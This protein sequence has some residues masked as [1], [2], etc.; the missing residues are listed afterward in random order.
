[1]Y[2]PAEHDE[3]T[4]LANYI[5]QQLQAIRASV[6]GL[7][8]AQAR[9][10]PCRSELSIAGIIKHITSLL[11]RITERLADGG[12]AASSVTID[13][14]AAEAFYAGFV[15]GPDESLTELLNSF[16]TARAQLLTAITRA[17]PDAAAIEPPAPWYGVPDSR[18]IR[19]R[20]A[21]THV[22]EELAR[23]AG[24]ADIIREQ[25]DGVSV[26]SIVLTQD[27]MAASDF[28][29][30]YRPVSGTIGS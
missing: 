10:T 26:P 9:E 30:P 15:L 20:Y 11:P 16:D 18:P 8:E 13:A 21:L 1:M 19:Q 3:I 28:F 6:I 4:N 24:H 12:T 25:L 7:T 17:D 29:E 22:I 27:G 5:D 23:H 14:A 2:A